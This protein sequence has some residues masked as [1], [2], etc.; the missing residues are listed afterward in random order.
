MCIPSTWVAFSSPCLATTRSIYYLWSP[1][2][3]NSHFYFNH[4]SVSF[5]A[6][7]WRCILQ[8][9]YLWT[10]FIRTNCRDVWRQSDSVVP[11]NAAEHNSLGQK[12]EGSRPSKSRKRSSTQKLSNTSSTPLV[13]QPNSSERALPSKGPAKNVDSSSV[14]TEPDNKEDEVHAASLVVI[15][16]LIQAQSSKETDKSKKLTH[17]G[18]PVTWVYCLALFHLSNSCFRI[19]KSLVRGLG[20]QRVVISLL[21][22]PLIRLTIS[23]RPAIAQIC[24]SW[25]FFH[26]QERLSPIDPG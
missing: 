17:V 25:F 24:G 21:L 15:S 5:G 12:S 13:Q 1:I 2:Q 6:H 14:A 9:V 26:D 18:A 8:H 16:S 4:I 23:F 7:R 11:I 19:M 10:L 3:T 20:L 22:F